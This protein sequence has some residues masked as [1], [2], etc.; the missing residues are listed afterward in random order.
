[1]Q[2]SLGH[3]RID[4]FKIDIEGYEWPLFE[5][6]PELSDSHSPDVVLPFQILVEIH[7]Q[8]GFDDLRNPGTARRSDFRFGRDMVNL[9]AHLLR[10][11]YVV[12][13]RDD[14][15]ACLHCTELTLIRA[16]C[17]STPQ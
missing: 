16:R 3:K 5:S 6:W 14:N 2:R 12:V 11:G 15:Q 17:H 9:Q 10:M 1:M 13:E 4:L 8:S 7:Y